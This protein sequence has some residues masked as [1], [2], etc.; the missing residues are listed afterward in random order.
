MDQKQYK[1]YFDIYQYRRNSTLTTWH[2][3]ISEDN[4]PVQIQKT[5]RYVVPDITDDLVKNKRSRFQ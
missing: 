4:H 2:R 5:I 1:T 3:V